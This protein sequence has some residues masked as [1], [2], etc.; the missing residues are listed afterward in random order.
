[1]KRFVGVFIFVVGIVVVFVLFFWDGLVCVFFLCMMG[2][3]EDW[4]G[5]L[6]VGGFGVV[7]FDFFCISS[8]I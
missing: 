7:V 4:G 8:L 1:M 6:R 3:I 5:F 2:F